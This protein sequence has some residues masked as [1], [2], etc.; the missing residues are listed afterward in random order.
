MGKIL[1]NFL[2]LVIGSIIVWL[3]VWFFFYNPKEEEIIPEDNQ[4]EVIFGDGA[5][6][7]LDEDFSATTTI[8]AK[9][10]VLINEEVVGSLYTISKE[11]EYFGGEVGIITFKIALDSDL[12]MIGFIEVLYEHTPS[13]KRFVRGFL[14]DL[15]GTNLN[16][17]ND[18]DGSTGATAT[19]TLLIT[20]LE[21]L[22]DVVN[23]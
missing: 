16:D 11:G 19:T 20:L 6:G 10:N 9:E 14:E 22:K 23:K 5:Q 2:N 18:L 7:V 8:I 3:I 15:V 21:D 17:F 13:Y 4:V 12:E 1:G